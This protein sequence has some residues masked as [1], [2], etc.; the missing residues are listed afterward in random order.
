MPYP[1]L[2]YR[3]CYRAGLVEPGEYLIVRMHDVTNDLAVVRSVE[4]G[5]ESILNVNHLDSRS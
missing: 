5:V 1:H 3:L 4:T 2:T